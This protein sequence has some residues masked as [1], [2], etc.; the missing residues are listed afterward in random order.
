MTH[1]AVR[2]FHVVS[3]WAILGSLNASAQ[4]VHFSEDSFDKATFSQLPLLQARQECVDSF[5]QK[6]DRVQAVAAFSPSDL[7]K[8]QTAGGIDIHRFFSDYAAF[9]RD[10][11]FGN[12]ARDQWQ[13]LS[14]ESRAAAK[15]F[16]EQFMNGLHGKGSIWRE[17]LERISSAEQLN[18]VDAIERSAELAEFEQ[19]IDAALL[20][21]GRQVA[22]TVE[23]RQEIKR[24]LV[25]KTTP[26]TLFGT[27]LMPL[28]FV[29]ARMGQVETELRGMFSEQDWQAVKKLIEAGE[30][31]TN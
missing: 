29:L 16:T 24:L 20:V 26:P 2:M 27:S 15:P 11:R 1:F 9:K 22:L 6:M 14:M 10:I 3:A 18:K 4:V 7:D 21:V 17:V 28:Y 25:E 13:K 5:N 12:I 8:L 19:Q 23:R 30:T 31:A